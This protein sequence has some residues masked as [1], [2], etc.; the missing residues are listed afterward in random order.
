MK[1][2]LTGLLLAGVFLA[3]AQENDLAHRPKSFNTTAGKA[4]FVD[5]QEATY[6]INY[7]VRAKSAAV[8]AEITFDAPEAGLP[9]FDS[10]EVPKSIVLD[11]EVV[12]SVISKTPS[13]ETNVRIIQKPVKVGSHKLSITVPLTALVSFANA[14]FRSAFWTSD[15]NERQFL[16]RY[17]PANFEF[18]Q[19]KMTFIVEYHGASQVHNIY[20]NG[21][22]ENAPHGITKITYPD[23]FTS[24]SIFFHLLPEKA[25]KELRFTLKSIDGRDIPAVV[26]Q[27]QKQYFVTLEKLKS[28]TTKVFHE[29]EKDYG[30]FPHPSITVYNAGQGGMEYCGATMTELGA[31]GHELFHSYF[32]RGVMPANGNAGWLDEALASWRDDGYKSSGALMGSKG[33]SSHPYYTRTTDRDA[34]TFGARFMSFM[35]TK[36]KDKGGLKP[37]MRHMVEFKK[38][39][40]LFVEDFIKEMGEFYGVSVEKEFKQHTYGQ[41]K[42]HLHEMKP[43]ENPIHRKMSVKELANYL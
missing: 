3:H 8:R 24:S 4:V 25:V 11:G 15:L 1:F 35:D 27:T 18:D 20:T 43:L 7:D 34:Y 23:Y 29:L 5:F 38:F 40:P 28:Q 22:I 13:A 32:A 16:E 12:T 19:V 42:D 39:A 33:L 14:E 21:V 26:Y 41:G 2:V 17:M 30:P 9:I 6:F 36:L 37:F 10:V 31:L